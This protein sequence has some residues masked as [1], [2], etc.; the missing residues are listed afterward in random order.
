M[1]YNQLCVVNNLT[2]FCICD[3][4]YDMKIKEEKYGKNISS[5]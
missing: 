2:I 4:I 3:I 1:V 5:R